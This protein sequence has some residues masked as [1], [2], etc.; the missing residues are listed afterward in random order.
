MLA[1]NRF[2]TLVAEDFF[3]AT[4]KPKELPNRATMKIKAYAA[5]MP[6]T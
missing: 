5:V 4:N 3:R 2:V 6:V 1:M